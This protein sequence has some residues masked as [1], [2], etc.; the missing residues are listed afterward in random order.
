MVIYFL[1]YR[2]IFY[3]TWL[4]TSTISGISLEEQE[5]LPCFSGVLVPSRARFRFFDLSGMESG[6]S[7]ATGVMNKLKFV[8][9]F[10]L[11]L[12][13]IYPGHDRAEGSGLIA[14]AMAC[15]PSGA[16][17]ASGGPGNCSGPAGTPQNIPARSGYPACCGEQRF[18][19][20]SAEPGR[21]DRARGRRRSDCH[22][23]DGNGSAPLSG[24]CNAV[25]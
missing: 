9:I 21:T 16:A 7:A 13:T 19:R 20:Q 25:E 22:G 11:M 3:N 1:H 6:N 24:P 10:I 17:F 2:T 15:D 12:P 23:G 4:L 5:Q 14:T 18:I 8:F